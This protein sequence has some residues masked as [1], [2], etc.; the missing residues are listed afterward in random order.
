MKKEQLYL[1]DD[2]DQILEDL[3]ALTDVLVGDDGGG[4][5]TQDVGAHGLDGVEIPGRTR[6]RGQNAVAMTR[7][8]TTQRQVG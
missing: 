2:L 4:Q 7:L 3:P 6:S 8:N 5:V 1:L